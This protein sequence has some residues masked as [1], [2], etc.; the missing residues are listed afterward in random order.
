MQ[1]KVK[2]HFIPTMVAGTKKT[3]NK[4]AWP[5]CGKLAPSYTANRDLQCKFTIYSCF[6]KIAKQLAKTL[7]T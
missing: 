6:G 2:C 1:I 7:I 5:G 3:D 4:K